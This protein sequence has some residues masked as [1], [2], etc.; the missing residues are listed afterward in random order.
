MAVCDTLQTK[1]IGMNI[2]KLGNISG[3]YPKILQKC[4]QLGLPC[5]TNKCTPIQT[6]LFFDRFIQRLDAGYNTF[7]IDRHK[8][9]GPDRNCAEWLMKCGAT[10]KFQGHDNH[11]L[12]YNALPS[13][14][15][16]KYKI[17]EID[18]TD[19][20]VML[21]GFPHLHNCKHVKKIVIHN[22]KYLCDSCIAYLPEIKSTLEH[23]QISSCRYVTSEGLI[24]ITELVNLKKLM[25]Y[26]LPHLEEKHKK[27]LLDLLKDAL[28]NCDT[29]FF[30]Q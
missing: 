2:V 24:P 12:E 4:M 1:N 3:K 16:D 10:I 26:D 22:C 30:K 15:F 29:E 14:N 20:T 27:P 19:S 21:K 28:P 17:E 6:R 9:V 7:D 13:S 23:L 25:I 8:L 11:I 18:M 5:I